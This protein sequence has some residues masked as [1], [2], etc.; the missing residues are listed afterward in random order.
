MVHQLIYCMFKRCMDVTSNIVGK[1]KKCIF[2]IS[3]HQ[4]NITWGISLRGWF[5]NPSAD[6]S[7]FESQN[8]RCTWTQIGSSCRKRTGM[9]YYLSMTGDK[10]DGLSVYVNRSPCATLVC[11]INLRSSSRRRENWRV[12]KLGHL[13]EFDDELALPY[14]TVIVK[15]TLQWRDIVPIGMFSQSL[16][17]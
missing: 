8:E 12:F 6:D 7:F 17:F 11:S 14:I 15:E 5:S 3:I 9:G 2:M 10:V 16:A 1:L 4:K 13:L